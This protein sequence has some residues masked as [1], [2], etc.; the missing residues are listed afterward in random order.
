M[1]GPLKESVAWVLDGPL[2]KES[3]ACAIGGPLK[4]SLCCAMDGPLM[5][6]SAGCTIGGP[7]K[8]SAYPSRQGTTGASGE[9]ART[10]ARPAGA[11][12]AIKQGLGVEPSPACGVKRDMLMFGVI[13]AGCGDLARRVG[14]LPITTA[15]AG[16][17]P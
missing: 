17:G 8:D 5:K 1:G 2:T 10:P 9:H 11:G 3:D 12:A 14:P 6:E 15:C 16:T 7:L 4:E 13:P